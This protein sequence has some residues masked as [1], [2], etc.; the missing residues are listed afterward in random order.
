MINQAAGMEA[1]VVSAILRTLAPKIFSLLQENH[2]L[3]RNL[4][5]DIQYI[6]RELR[7]IAAAIEDHDQQSLS[8]GA[9]D[10]QRFWIEAV[11]E[12]AYSIE[13]SIDRFLHRVT[14][15]P[16]TLRQRGHQLKMATRTSFAS[17]IRELRRKS[18]EIS[19]LRDKYIGSGGGPSSS[20]SVA[21]A[22]SKSSNRARTFQ[23]DTTAT[24]TVGM[25]GPISEL[26]ELMRE[27][28]GQSGKLKVISIVGFGGL[29]KT[30]LARHAYERVA[31]EEQYEPCIWVHASENSAWCVL[32]EILSKVTGVEDHGYFDNFDLSNLIIN[33]RNCLEPKR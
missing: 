27:A 28:E 15:E 26:L 14:G 31:V 29:G 22:T 9:S 10:V 23:T 33:L 5:C 32:K 12:L 19:K 16:P 6:R 25:E 24:D 17:E 2:R 21:S 1:A 30:V 20:S 13:D 3:Q 11:R 18:E 7:M 8:N 4:E